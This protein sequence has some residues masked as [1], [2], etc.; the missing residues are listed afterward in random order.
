MAEHQA[1]DVLYVEDNPNDVELA[2]RA[3]KKQGIFN[4]VQLARDGVEALEFLQGAA[5]A[6]GARS[7][8]R[9]II[10]DLKLSRVS[11]LEVLRRIRE[12]ER[13]RR[14]P[15]V[16]LTSSRERPDVAAAYALGVNSY[17]VKPVDFET[18][19]DVVGRIGRY[20]LQLNEPAR[21]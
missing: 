2:L 9:L 11:G 21:G 19:M 16:I 15:V 7:G 13:T 3:L 1:V 20:W 14:T 10:L 18:F 17:I 12:D 4:R 8:L 5:D 6:T